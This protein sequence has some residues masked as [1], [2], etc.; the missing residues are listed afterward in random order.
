VAVNAGNRKQVAYTFT[1]EDEVNGRPKVEIAYEE[2]VKVE[3]V[4][5]EPTEGVEPTVKEEPV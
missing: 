1:A 5:M 3:A 4:K 2:D